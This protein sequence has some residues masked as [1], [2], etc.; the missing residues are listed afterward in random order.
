MKNLVVAIALV[1]SM[2][3]CS[4]T[5]N[6]Q[7]SEL[8]KTILEDKR[9]D[10]VFEM[11]KETLKPEDGE[12]K[13]GSNYPETWIR[14]FAT[15]VEVALEVNSKEVIKERLLLFF[16]FQGEDGNIV[17]GYTEIDTEAGYDY[18]LF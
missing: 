15:F 11:A 14:D 1:I 10:T 12:F 4:D 8:A 13:A 5:K 7:N 16:D 9:L 6:P 3:A 18:I 17:D 2:I